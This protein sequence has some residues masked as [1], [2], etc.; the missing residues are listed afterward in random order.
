MSQTQINLKDFL[1]AIASGKKVLI[2]GL[3]KENQQFIHWLST[4]A[5]IPFK[6]LYFADKAVPVLPLDW[7]KPGKTFYG[8]DYLNSLQED[9]VEYVFKAPGIWSLLPEF[10]AFRQKKGFDRVNSSLVFFIQKFKQNII[11][12]TGT[13]GKS[14]TSALINH[15]LLE[16]DYQSNYCGNTTGISP[17]T[18]WT[19]INQELDSKQAFV[20]ELS[21]F[22]LQDLGF[23]SISPSY[24][25]I[26]NYYIDHLD[27]HADSVEYWQAKDNIFKFQNQES[28]LVIST[29][30]VLEHSKVLPEV[31][32]SFIVD[33]LTVDRLH[34]F[35]THNLIGSHNQFNVTE[36]IIAVEAFIS[37]V[38]T[39]GQILIAIEGMSAEYTSSLSKF[40]SLPH[41]LELIRSEKIAKDGVQINLNFYDDGFATEPD[42]VAAAIASLTRTSQDFI[43]L[44]VTGIDKGGTMDKLIHR[45]QSTLH[46]GKYFRADYCGQVGQ[47]I[48]LKLGLNKTELVNFHQTTEEMLLNMD[49]HLQTFRDFIFY[50]GL[51]K[52]NLNIV[53]SPCGSSFDEFENYYK[54]CDWWVEKIQGIDFKND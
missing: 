45:I 33:D 12:V 18:F 48:S 35:V 47:N 17:Y 6:S 22:Q 49:N 13:K 15:L 9:T 38:H 2:I 16:S 14:T 23:A 53:L 7:D 11:A 20:V 10:E 41:R 46:Q 34:E 25:V 40:K 51:D 28:D 19:E 27:Q 54:R 26:T 29:N 4:T 24:S 1:E 36:A 42:A 44:I 37:K 8:E 32:N 43:W 50:K 21:S 30:Q 5:K 39:L 3:G 31:T 52:A